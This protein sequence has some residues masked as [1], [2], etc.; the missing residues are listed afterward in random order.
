M[1]WTEIT[2]NRKLFYGFE[3]SFCCHWMGDIFLVLNLRSLSL[4]FPPDDFE[5]EML[6]SN[7]V[8]SRKR[9]LNINLY[10][11]LSVCVSHFCRF[12]SF[13]K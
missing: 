8:V 11:S 9:S 5:C 6:H 7:L 4:S 2:V 13:R 10:L 3:C 12:L 1:R